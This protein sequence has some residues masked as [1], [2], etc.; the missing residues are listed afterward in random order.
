[1]DS[2]L[3][4]FNENLHRATQRLSLITAHDS[5][6]I[7][8]HS[9]SAPKLSYVLR[10]APCAGH[11][12][13]T[14]FNELLRKALCTVINVS[15]SD[16]QWSLASLPIGMGGLG[17]RGVTLLA[18]SAFLASAAGSL[19]LQDRILAQPQWPLDSEVERNQTIWSSI[20][21][22]SILQVSQSPDKVNGMNS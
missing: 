9:L 19:L 12:A 6:I 11:P 21:S 13:L 15:L 20:T 8:R 1:M 14:R 5:L 7:R 10:C 4:K 2:S 18:S 16:D 3:D 17:V 22:M